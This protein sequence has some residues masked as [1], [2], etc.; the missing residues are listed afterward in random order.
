MLLKENY[1]NIGL[2]HIACTHL[3][4]FLDGNKDLSTDLR[5]ETF[6]KKR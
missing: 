4:V 6:T 3:Y 5:N 2:A 1:N